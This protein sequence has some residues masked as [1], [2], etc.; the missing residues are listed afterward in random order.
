MDSGLNELIGFLR[1]NK[2]KKFK[3]KDYEIEFNDSAF[4]SFDIVPDIEQDI[5]T[6]KQ[7]FEDDLFY[8]ARS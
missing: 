4:H 6:D 1:D 7:S 8:S 5:K 3:N 2:I